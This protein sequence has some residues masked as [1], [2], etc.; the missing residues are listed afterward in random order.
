MVGGSVVDVVVD[1]V[2]DGSIVEGVDE[3][4]VL[5]HPAATKMTETRKRGYRAESLFTQEILAGGCV[6][7]LIVPRVKV[8]RPLCSVPY[9]KSIG[10][11]IWLWLE[12]KY[13]CS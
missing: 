10:D 3:L 5:E 9:L 4:G 6:R 2:V 11:T 7:F 13:W 12:K 1:V 8:K